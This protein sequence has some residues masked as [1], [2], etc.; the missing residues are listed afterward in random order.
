MKTEDPPFVSTFLGGRVYLE[1]PRV[2]RYSILDIAHALSL[3][4]RYAGQCP[5]FYSVAQH[6]VLVSERASPADALW[7]LLHDA[8]EAYL[9]D[10]PRPVKYLPA[11]AGYRE[12]EA[13]IQS[14]IVTQFGLPE[15]EPSSVRA[16]D[17][18]LARQEML[19]FGMRALDTE[20][21]QV[22]VVPLEN[23]AD[24]YHLFMDRFY[25]L[26]YGRPIREAP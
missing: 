17:K 7:G 3:L 20:E 13:R 22:R 5:R 6:S 12:L 4:C 25:T 15:K 23:P 16:A 8:S 26:Y 11:L 24:A 9:V 19:S 21:L 18:L 2:N 14:A 10:V 1:D